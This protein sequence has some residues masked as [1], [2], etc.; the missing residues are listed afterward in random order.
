MNYARLLAVTITGAQ[1]TARPC[2]NCGG[3]LKIEPVDPP[4]PDPRPN[5]VGICGDC[6][7]GADSGCRTY[8]GQTEAE[9]IEDWNDDN[10]GIECGRCGEQY[11]AAEK[12]PDYTSTCPTC[13]PET[14][15]FCQRENDRV[16][17]HDG[18][19]QSSEYYDSCSRCAEAT[20][21]AQ[22]CDHLEA[23]ADEAR[24]ERG[25]R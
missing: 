19:V 25:S 10:P 11:C 14:C 18:P 13:R 2:D 12:D 3:S 22:Y 5:Y 21:Y 9:V 20:A 6:Y 23:K 16:L 8:P 15:R 4:I 17:E 7:D 1:W 24:D